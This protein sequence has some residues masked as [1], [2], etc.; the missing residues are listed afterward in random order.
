MPMS[1]NSTQIKPIMLSIKKKTEYY[2][3]KKK[4]KN[5]KK[6]ITLFST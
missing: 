5:T 1:N 4:P 3:D 2:L 6:Y